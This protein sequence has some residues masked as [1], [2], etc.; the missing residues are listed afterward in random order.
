MIIYQDNLRDI[1]TYHLHGF[2]VGWPNPPSPAVHLRLLAGSSHVLLARN[3]ADGPVI[4]FITAM[5]DGVLCAYIPLL[6]VLPAYQGQGIGRE[7]VRRMLNQLR[8]LYMV[9]LICDESLQPFYERLGMERY[10]CMIIRNYDHQ[11]GV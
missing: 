10:S 11:S 8:R 3:D 7:L 6:E 1:T 5:S 4:G 9:D 2:F